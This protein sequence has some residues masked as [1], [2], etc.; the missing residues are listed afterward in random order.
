[1]PSRVPRERVRNRRIGQLIREG[2]PREQAAA[3]AYKEWRERE[4]TEN[5]SP[6]MATTWEQFHEE[7]AV[8]LERFAYDYDPSRQDLAT[9]RMKAREL[10]TKL[11]VA[12]G[13]T[14]RE[15]TEQ[16]KKYPRT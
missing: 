10:F 7:L 8:F 15:Q 16:E 14:I 13:E 12:M 11:Q 3:I 6:Y 4:V 1:M 5:P 2:Y 9:Y